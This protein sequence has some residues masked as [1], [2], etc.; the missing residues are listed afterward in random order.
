MT[1]SYNLDRPLDAD[2]ME[3]LLTGTPQPVGQFVLTVRTGEWWWSDGLY[4]MH[5]FKP[6]EVVPTTELMLA[7]KHPDDRARVQ[8][9]L[10]DACLSGEPFACVHRIIDANGH[11]RTLGV[12]GR[13]RKEPGSDQV[14]QVS[15]YFVDLTI[16]QRELSQREASAAIQASAKSRAVI[17]QAKGAVMTVYGMSE[18]EAFDLLRHH[19]SVTNESIRHLARRLMLNLAEGSALAAPTADDLDLFFEA[20]PAPAGDLGENGAP[21]STRTDRAAASSPN[22]AAFS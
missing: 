22:L 12:V 8:A 5:G 19:S 10:A 6:G 13:G 14:T 2:L 3:V 16:T 1:T 7:H 20:T 4:E 18:N 21:T 9:L 17:E 15:G 11:T